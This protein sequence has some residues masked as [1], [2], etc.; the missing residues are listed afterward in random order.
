[1]PA[2]ILVSSGVSRAGLR[3]GSKS[4]KCKWLVKVDASNGATPDYKKSMARGGF[5][6]TRN[7]LDTRLGE[8]AD[9][10]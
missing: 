5:R 4:R 6:A 10:L 9:K 2:F 1:M 8:D 3:G 7:P